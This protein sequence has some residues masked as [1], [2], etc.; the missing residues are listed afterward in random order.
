MDN[1]RINFI[2]YGKALSILFVLLI[3][4]GIEI[5]KDYVLF[6]MP[7]FFIV[8]G[9]VLN[10]QNKTLKQFV[11]NRFMKLMI[12]FLI[13]SLLDILLE[14]ARAYFYGYGNYKIA[15]P[16]LINL[17]YG[18]G[19]KVPDLFGVRELIVTNI[20][21]IQPSNQFMDVILPTN[22]HLW[23]LPAMFTASIFAFIILKNFKDRK[24]VLVVL[25]FILVLVSALESLPNVVQLPF[26]IGRGCIGAVFIIVGY[27]LKEHAVFEKSKMPFKIVIVAVTSVIAL[28]FIKLLGIH[29][30]GMVR[31]QF[32]SFG[33]WGTYLTF[34]GGTVAAIAVLTLF[35]ILERVG[36][37][38]VGKILSLV[39]R[40][41]MEIYLYQFLGFFVFEVLFFTIS[42]QSV[43]P[44]KYWMSV[45]PQSATWFM[46]FETIMVIAII[47]LIKNSRAVRH[48]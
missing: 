19:F 37:G 22:C 30:E 43:S 2:D 32:G 36:I 46:F 23:F 26:C 16:S 13:A 47:V 20:P 45:L 1:K 14:I 42:G 38:F 12:P 5:L 25:S 35:N 24:I 11:K 8:S 31:S 40:N 39:G 10:P 48:K 15:I 44:D 34:V 21:Y 3:H 27:F 6:A 7:L 18:S 29:G 41:T 33:I 4:S 28:V 9:Y 17:L